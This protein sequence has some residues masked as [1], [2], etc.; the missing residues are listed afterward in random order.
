MV[1]EAS[2]KLDVSEF[3]QRVVN[4]ELFG[5][6]LDGDEFSLTIGDSAVSVPVKVLSFPKDTK[7]LNVVLFFHGAVDQEKREIP[8]FYGD[9][10]AKRHPANTFVLSI[11][12]PSLRLDKRIFS[13]FYAGDF[14]VP[15]RQIIASLSSC[16][17]T[18][19]PNNRFIFVGASTGAHPALYH[20]FFIDKSVCLVCNPILI[21][22]TYWEKMIDVYLEKAWPFKSKQEIF[23]D[24]VRD[25]IVALYSNPSSNTVVITQNATDPY[26]VS[27]TGKLVSAFPNNKN[28]L[29]LSE[30]F[31]DQIGHTYPSARFWSSVSAVINASSTSVGDIAKSLCP[32]VSVNTPG[33]AVTG[34]AS[35]KYI[36]KLLVSLL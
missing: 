10:T 28:L 20:S 1:N 9:Q 34:S 11:S 18:V 15:T 13:A 19:F 23:S 5:H 26:L 29:F 21:M 16:L 2:N 35:D 30:Y 32:Q 24:F 6:P 12:D 8:V 36:A 14:E 22:Q 31:P 25:D 3:I 17:R 33:V 27:M 7:G 4:C